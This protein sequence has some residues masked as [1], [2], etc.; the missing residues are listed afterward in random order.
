MALAQRPLADLF[1]RQPDNQAT[2]RRPEPAQGDRLG[3]RIGVFA[4]C[5]YAQH[6]IGMPHDIG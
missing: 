2:R 6:V 5:G 3:V 4:G 1:A